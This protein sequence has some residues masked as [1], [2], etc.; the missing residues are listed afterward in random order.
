MK[1]HKSTPG[2]PPSSL[3]LERPPKEVRAFLTRDPLNLAAL[4]ADVRRDSDGGLATFLGVVRNEN[5]GQRVSRIEYT[6]YEPMAELE[7]QK[8][9]AELAGE[10][11]GTQVAMRHRLGTLAI[12]EA[13]VAIAAASPHRAE[14]FAACRAAIEKIKLRVPI[15]KKEMQ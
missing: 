9:D 2:L 6:A 12:G 14:A 7:A 8:I 3:P 11:P 13:S 10:F 15:W 5:D 4:I 1:L